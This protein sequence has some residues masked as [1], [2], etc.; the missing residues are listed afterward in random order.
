MI[1]VLADTHDNL[2]AVR[3]AVRLFA[4]AGVD[5]II[6]A[7]DFVAPF[8]A[9]ALL[10]A[11]CPIR[12]VFGN[13]DGEKAGLARALGERGEVRE[14]PFALEHA[15]RTFLV[16]HQREQLG[17]YPASPDKPGTHTV[18]PETVHVPNI[19]IFGHTHR[20]R[21]ERAGATLLINP[22]EA[23]G[24]L[25][26]RPTAVLLDPATLAAELVYLEIAGT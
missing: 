12:G 19:H 3:A 17:A 7:G 1:G 9:R 22:G 15:G 11:G 16:A 14:P 2:V 23:G 25:H 26:G 4:A 10:E 13:C 5:L 20:P 24:W 21:I 8:T 6:H 18:S